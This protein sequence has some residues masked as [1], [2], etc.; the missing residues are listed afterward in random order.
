MFLRIKK[1]SVCSH[2]VV[3]SVRVVFASVCAVFASCFLVFSKCSQS[4]RAVF[5]YRQNIWHETAG[6][7]I[8][9]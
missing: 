3:S 4:V 1:P 8:V 9:T 6:N 7:F 5:S 2:L